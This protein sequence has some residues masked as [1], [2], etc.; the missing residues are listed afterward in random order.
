M[1]KLFLACAIMA[2]LSVSA[3]QGFDDVQVTSEPVVDG[4]HMFTGAGGNIGVSIGEDGVLIIDDQFAPLAG[5]ITATLKELT[6]KPARFVIN[7]HHHGDHTGSNAFF[8]SEQGATIFAHHNVRIRMDSA[9]R[10][11]NSGKNPSPE[12]LPLVTYE[13]GVKFHINGQ[14]VNVFHL[15]KAH[16]DG[17][18]A[19]IFEEANVLHTG[20]LFF[21][22]IFPFIDIGGGGNV[23]GYIAAIENMLSKIDDETK[24]I[25]G[26]GSLANKADLQ[27]AVNM[28]KETYAY[29]QAK[30]EAGMSEAQVLEA[31]LEEKWDAWTWQFI[32]EERWIKTLYQ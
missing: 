26:H 29:V 6:D 24:I 23:E 15:S 17:D 22:D 19:V 9:A 1:K 28:V 25:P 14:T 4:I 11:A 13:D 27:R 18:S 12:A 8:A 20:D 21:K 10:V 7:T 2:P 5:K 3:M 31:G 16:T 32:N 30:K